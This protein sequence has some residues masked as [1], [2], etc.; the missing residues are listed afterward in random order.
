MTTQARERALEAL[1]T[2][3]KAVP[4]I[5]TVDRQGLRPEMLTEGNL[6]AI[7][8]TEGQTTY[9][10]SVKG[11]T[12]EMTA[13]DRLTLDVQ[14]RAPR[15]ASAKGA[16]YDASTT[17]ALYVGAILSTLAKNRALHVQLEGEDEAR[18]HAQHLGAPNK[19]GTFAKVTPAPE[20]EPFCRAL[21]Q[22][23]MS[24]IDAHVMSEGTPYTKILLALVEPDAQGDPDPSH[25][26]LESH[27]VELA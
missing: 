26:T 10:A 8:I 19:Q 17:R 24:T 18:E 14:A 2:I 5:R 16:A 13:R 6:P 9:E 3:L 12:L 23:E 27:T 11:N 1:K 22:I 20:P 15:T 21:I 25:P 7:L 4:G